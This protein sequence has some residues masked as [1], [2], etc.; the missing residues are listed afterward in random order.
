ME[1]K[2]LPP[3]Y[4]APQ[5]K[6]ICWESVHSYKCGHIGEHVWLCVG[7][8]GGGEVVCVGSLLVSKEVFQ[9]KSI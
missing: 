7:G 1:G 3:V 4:I 6:G 5:L 9:L 2:S 8:G